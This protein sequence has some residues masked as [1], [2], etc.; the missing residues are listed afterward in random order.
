M[1]SSSPTPAGRS[2]LHQQSFASSDQDLHR[3]KVASSGGAS[4]AR[5]MASDAAAAVGIQVKD[6]LDR[7]VGSGCDLVSKF[8]KSAMR[9]A[10]DLNHE[11]PQLAGLV[12]GAANRLDGLANDFHDRSVDELVRSASDFTRRQP[13][14]VFGLAAV[15]GFVALRTVYSASS[16][17][18][19]SSS[20]HANRTGSFHGA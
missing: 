11:A 8:A 9:A 5:E 13:A 19:N 12:R 2:G 14:L 7:Q 1:S 6:L 4:E 18:L 10:D 17:N 15:A 20:P 3:T 16:A